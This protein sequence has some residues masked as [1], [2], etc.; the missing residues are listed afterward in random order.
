MSTMICKFPFVFC[1]MSREDIFVPYG[2]DKDTHKCRFSVNNYTSPVQ[3]VFWYRYFIDVPLLI[4]TR[5]IF[6]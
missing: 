4:T 3:L 1:V 2:I 6:L 5:S